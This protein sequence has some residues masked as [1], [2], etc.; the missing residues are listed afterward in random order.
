M[1]GKLAGV[2]VNTP[3]TNTK[4]YTPPDGKTG[5]VTLSICNLTT[6]SVKIRV[7]INGQ[8]NVNVGNYDWI[9]FDFQLD[10]GN[11][12]ERTGIVLFNNTTGGTANTL[13]VSST[14]NVAAVVW[15][16]VQ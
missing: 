15:G 7:A 5:V 2:Y 13:V 8:D 14:G 3:N 16:F 6:Q 11:T 4:I 9:E 1:S 12:Y 10:P